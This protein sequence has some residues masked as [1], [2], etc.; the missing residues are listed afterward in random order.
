M[1]R[2]IFRKAIVRWLPLLLISPASAW[3]D[4]CDQLPPP[5]ITVKRLDEP[6]TLNLTYGYRSLTNIGASIASPG[7]Q[8]LG[9]TRGMAIVSFE[10]STRL[11]VDR[12]GRWECASPQISVT[13][14]FR[15]MT[16]Y[17]ARE[18]SRGSCAHEEIYQHELRHV[19]TYQ[20]HMQGI[21]PEIRRALTERFTAGK[22]WRGPIGQTQAQLQKELDHR[23]MPYIKL[24][25]QRVEP[26]QAL[27]DTPE[28]YARV[29]DSC[30]G[31][32]RKVL[33]RP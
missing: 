8:I 1:R 25:L 13:Y 17:V 6:V 10:T 14:G 32:I 33:R 3:A 7:R 12:S 16:V 22:P 27:I 24:L 19:E 29:A 11:L 28:E 20:K 2:L 23:W 30:G 21:E 5:S 18:F 9:L 26:Q 31:E 4:P 15:P